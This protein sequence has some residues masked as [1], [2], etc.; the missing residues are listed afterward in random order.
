MGF[1]NSIAAD[2]KHI[3]RLMKNPDMKPEDE[4]AEM[5]KWMLDEEIA[6]E[7]EE[8]FNDDDSEIEEAVDS[9][10]DGEQCANSGTKRKLE[11]TEANHQN[12]KQKVQVDLG[13][14]SMA[15]FFAKEEVNGK[16][17]K[18]SDD[19][20]TVK[21]PGKTKK[22]RKLST[23]EREGLAMQMEE[24]IRQI[25]NELAD[26]NKT[27]ESAEQFERLLLA[28]PNS[29]KIWAQYIAFHLSVSLCI[30]YVEKS[31]GELVII[32]R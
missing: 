23:A 15:D 14:P 9:N 20:E 2:F 16:E 3:R 7:T 1:A 21:D 5:A 28:R 27:P 26:P 17:E 12:K 32:D 31:V 10:W 13:F 30:L 6:N 29:S 4:D 19:E 8:L 25:E 24:R 18:S 22:K 11:T